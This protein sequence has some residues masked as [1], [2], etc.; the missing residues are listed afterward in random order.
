MSKQRQITTLFFLASKLIFCAS[1]FVD[2][3]SNSGSS[4]AYIVSAIKTPIKTL[5]IKLLAL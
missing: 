2:H 3:S 1:D 4:S 5:Q